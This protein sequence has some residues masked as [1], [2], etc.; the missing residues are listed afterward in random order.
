MLHESETV[1]GT[2]EHVRSGE[3]R[4]G[5]RGVDVDE[6]KPQS[7]TPLLLPIGKKLDV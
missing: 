2:K 7:G 6:K 5:V 3:A 4:A 1:Q